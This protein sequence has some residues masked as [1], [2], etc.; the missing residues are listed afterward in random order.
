[1]KQLTEANT[2]KTYKRTTTFAIAKL[3]ERQLYGKNI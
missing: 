1:M 2:K 3:E